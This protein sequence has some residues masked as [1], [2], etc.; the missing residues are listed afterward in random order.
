MEFSRFEEGNR[1]S[2]GEV[3]TVDVFVEGEYID[4]VGFKKEKDF[5]V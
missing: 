2:L 4:V 3:L 5:K 1:K